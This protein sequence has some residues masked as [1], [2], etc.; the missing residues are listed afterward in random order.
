MVIHK[1]LTRSRN[2]VQ[3]MS[4]P[5]DAKV[6]VRWSVTSKITQCKNVQELMM[7]HCF[8]EREYNCSQPFICAFAILKAQ[9]R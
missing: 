9:R 8:Y 6:T 1:L 5:H 3:D 2:D 4:T 7:K